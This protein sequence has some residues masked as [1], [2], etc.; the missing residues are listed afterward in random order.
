MS[1]EVNGC[2]LTGMKGLSLTAMIAM[3]AGAAAIAM[4]SP[5]HAD[6]VSFNETLHSYGIYAPPDKTAYL[7][8]ISCHRLDT[9]LDK[10]AYQATNFL[11][12]NLDRGTSTEQK[13][14]FLSA[15]IDEYCPEQRPVLERAAS[16]T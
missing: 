14:Q 4:A 8:K 16:H 1:P 15:S 12:K 2:R 9:G 10:D 13:W 5:A 6:D 3:G 7:G 11:T